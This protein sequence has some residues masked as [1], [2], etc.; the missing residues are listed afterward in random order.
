[1]ANNRK[2]TTTAMGNRVGST[3]YLLKSSTEGWTVKGGPGEGWPLVYDPRHQFDPNP[4][5]T[6]FNNPENNWRYGS[7]ECWAE[8]PA[9][10]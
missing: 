6:D 9:S 8:P 1:M 7:R 2:N 3:R 4:F 5:R 10:K